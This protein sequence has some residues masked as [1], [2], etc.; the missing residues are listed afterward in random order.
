MPVDASIYANLKGP[1]NPLDMV[2]QYAGLQ[3]QLNQNRLFQGEQA[4]GQAL[5]EGGGDPNQVRNLLLRDPRAAIAAPQIMS[6]ALAQQIQAQQVGTSQRNLAG[7]IA[8]TV[9]VKADGTPDTFGVLAA[10][11]TAADHKLVDPDF[12]STLSGDG[13]QLMNFIKSSAIGGQGGPGGFA[14][15]YGETSVQTVPGGGQR[16]ENINPVTQQVNF[17]GGSASNVAPAL[18]PADLATQ[19]E[20]VDQGTGK[21]TQVPRSAFM[22][23][24]G[25]IKPDNGF[26]GPKGESLAS[27]GPFD[28]AQRQASAQEYAA[29]LSDTA[30]QQTAGAQLKT[31]DSLLQQPEAK[32]GPGTQVVNGWRNFVLGN[33]PVLAKVFPGLDAA[34]VQSA[35][36]DEVKKYMAQIALQQSGAFG[37][38]TNEKLAAAASGNANVD[39][40]NLANRD[41]TRMNLALV[42]AQQA[43][44][45][46]F[47]Q[48]GQDPGNYATWAANWNR[49]VDPRAFMLDSLSKEERQ[50]MLSGIK[51]PAER[52]ALLRG[53]EAA[54][55]AGLYQE[56]DIPQ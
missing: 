50:K 7:Q 2:G 27:L 11:K 31:L 44:I 28:A 38:S 43:R 20:V 53:K 46:A 1:P 29:D 9:P 35:T 34:K 4:G 41:V 10:L 17:A 51:A 5:L 49:N 32:T 52:A 47:Q 23:P 42:R 12:V 54:E 8:A 22:N 25:S 48:S 39:M 40:S 15:Q 55:Q 36:Q 26:T 16:A 3:N 33:F 37:P 18:T 6:A 30:R 56:S 21:H 24:D 14:N 45:A 19:V 13:S